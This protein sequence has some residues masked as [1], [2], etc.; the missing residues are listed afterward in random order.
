V[1]VRALPSVNA[2]SSSDWD[3]LDKARILFETRD[4]LSATESALPG[5]PLITAEFGDEGLE[6]LIVWRMLRSDDPSPYFNIGSLLARLTSS[7]RLERGRWTL[8]CAGMEMH[9]QMLAA[10][11]IEIDAPRLRGHIMAAVA[12]RD[13]PPVMCGVNFLPRDPA[14]GLPRSL[15]Q[16]GF[17][18]IRGYQQA[19]LEIRGDSFDDYLASLNPHQRRKVRRDRRLYAESG[20]RISIGTGP[21][22]AG[23]DLIRLHGT[24]RRKYGGPD[25]EQ[26]LRLFHS[27]MIR[28]SGEDS[29]VIRTYRGEACVGFAMFLRSGGTLHGMCAGF[30]EHSDKVGPYFECVYYAAV[31]WAYR[32]NIQEIDY[33]IGAT[34]AKSERGCR[35]ID[36]STWFLP[37]HGSLLGSTGRAEVP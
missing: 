25:E 5:E 31:E 16:L 12:M 35:I 27:A 26:E 29:L 28:S 34:M 9:S 30:E 17:Q 36:V 37:P 1:V 18:E 2:V 15:A 6:S 7:P 23:E 13:E 20:Q 14:P 33:G 10:P 3:R 21:A 22:A 11:G 24:N 4:W 8:N 19:I 32:N